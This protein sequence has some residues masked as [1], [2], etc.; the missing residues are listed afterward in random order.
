MSTPWI[1]SQGRR[2]QRAGRSLAESGVHWRWSQNVIGRVVGGALQNLT[3][4][5]SIS[6]S[7]REE[8]HL[9][10]PFTGS[11]LTEL[12]GPEPA[13]PINF[14]GSTLSRI[15][16]AQNAISLVRSAIKQPVSNPVYVYWWG[17]QDIAWAQA[18]DLR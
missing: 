12:N 4:Q 9:Q 5:T 15:S 13:L 8:G 16:S 17:W 3:S 18:Y 2:G 6:G 14:K 7:L 1:W 10:L 11:R